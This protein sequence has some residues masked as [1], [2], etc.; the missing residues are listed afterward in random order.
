MSEPVKHDRFRIQVTDDGPYGM[1]AVRLDG[2]TIAYINRNGLFSLRGETLM[3]FKATDLE[4]TKKGNFYGN[5]QGSHA[6]VHGKGSSS[7]GPCA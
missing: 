7:G 3:K 2:K 1:H 4:I 5:V 6:G